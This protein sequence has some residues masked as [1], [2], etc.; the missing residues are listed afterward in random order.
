MADGDDL[1][2]GIQQDIIIVNVLGGLATVRGVCRRER[3]AR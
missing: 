2:F 3:A 1:A